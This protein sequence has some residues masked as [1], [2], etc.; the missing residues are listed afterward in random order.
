VAI[1]EQIP[2]MQNPDAEDA[3]PVNYRG[4]LV[5]T[6]MG[7]ERY[8]LLPKNHRLGGSFIDKLTIV[9]N[10]SL[11]ILGIDKQGLRRVQETRKQSGFIATY[12]VADSPDPRHR[13]V[14]VVNVA[15]EGQLGLGKK[16]ST[17]YT[18]RW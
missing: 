5:L 6:Q 16:I 13:L 10:S 11:V 3:Q 8:L 2:G 17:I 18:Y 9:N 4:R 14:H 15:Q 7:D 1:K 12:Q